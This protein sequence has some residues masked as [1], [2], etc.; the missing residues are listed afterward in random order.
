MA[1]AQQ[2]EEVQPAF[3]GRRAEPGEVAV[4]DLR[5]GAVRGLVA[6]AGVID[7]DP[8]GCV[9]PARSTSRASVRKASWP[10][11][12]RRRICRVEMA[13]PMVRSCATK[14]GT[15]TCP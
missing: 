10:S 11:F 6:G 5:A 4:A 9:S 7:R 13:K 14:R 8:G 15:V 2:L 12:N 1:G 3:A